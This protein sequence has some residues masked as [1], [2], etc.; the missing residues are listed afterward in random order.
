MTPIIEK[1]TWKKVTRYLL[2]EQRVQ[3][4]SGNAITD[5]ALGIGMFFGLSCKVLF[6]FGAHRQDFLVDLFCG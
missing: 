3:V 1:V 5:T 2:P 6:H 4:R